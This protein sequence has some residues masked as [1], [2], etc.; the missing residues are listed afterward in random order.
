MPLL[1]LNRRRA[2]RHAES[3]VPDFN[4][5]LLTFAERQQHADPFLE[6]LAA[7]TMQVASSTDASEMVRSRTIAGALSAATLGAGVLIWLILAGP[8][9]WGHGASLLWAGTTRPG[10]PSAFYEVL[11]EPGNRSVRR[12]SDQV[13]TAQLIGFS[14]D[15]VSLFAKF[16][17][18]SKWE[19][20]V[21]QRR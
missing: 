1:R 9:F 14:T 19:H 2:A 18:T 21:M 5:R 20:V 15:R 4:D 11:V 13:V 8:G 16:A 12:N 3:A 17:G 7:D 6:L 10:M